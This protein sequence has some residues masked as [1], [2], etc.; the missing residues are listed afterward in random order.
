MFG[1]TTTGIV[2]DF[3][4]MMAA[5]AEAK[6]TRK[7]GERRELDAEIVGINEDDMGKSKIFY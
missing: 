4:A 6:A 7:R 2:C 3:R 1:L 5:Y